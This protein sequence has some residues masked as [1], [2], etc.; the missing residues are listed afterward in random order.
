MNKRSIFF[1]IVLIY[2]G[3]QNCAP[4]EGTGG[5]NLNFSVGQTADFAQVKSILDRNCVT[6][7]TTASAQN[8]NVALGSYQAIMDSGIVIGGNAQNSLL[9]GVIEDGSMPQGLPPLSS[10]QAEAIRTWINAGAPDEE[11]G[12]ANLLPIIDMP[13]NRT[14]QLPVDSVEFLANVRDLDGAVLRTVW[15]QVSGPN[16]A[17]FNGGRTPILLVSGVQQGTYTFELLVEDDFGAVVTARV[18]LVV[19]STAS[20]G[21]PPAATVSFAS[22]IQPILA[23]NCTS[24][25]GANNPRG[26][27]S[28]NTYNGTISR[29]VAQNP[30]QSLLY[31]RVLNDSM[32]AGGATPLQAAEKALI[33][34][35]IAE[36]AQ[37]N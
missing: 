22:D 33:R 34:D 24:C 5:S 16:T 3:F 20:G 35:W 26:N 17:T 25:H 11:G 12:V 14:V 4:L 9:Y 30:N 29:V 8:G 2:F 28:L 6:C 18:I 15:S 32:P 23:A 27:Y 21:N 1:L 7:H 19:Q 31:T 36:G 37:N 13:D 10:P